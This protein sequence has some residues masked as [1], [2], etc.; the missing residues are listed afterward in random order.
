MIREGRLSTESQWALED[1]VLA[2]A[3]R[4]EYMLSWGEMV[5]DQ[6]MDLDPEDL[7]DEQEELLAGG[8]SPTSTYTTTPALNL[9]LCT[10]KSRQRLLTCNSLPSMA[11]EVT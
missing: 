8:G 2:E 10:S 3:L 4:R 11:K 1:A 9:D 5:L 7:R 6:E